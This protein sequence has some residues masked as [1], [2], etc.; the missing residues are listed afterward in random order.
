MLKPSHGHYYYYY[1]FLKCLAIFS[2]LSMAFLFHP[3]AH[4]GP[5]IQAIRLGY[6]IE[7][8]R[9]VFDL[10][11][12][13]YNQQWVKV[14]NTDQGLIINLQNT[15]LKEKF[16]KH[17]PNHSFIKAIQCFSSQNG[18]SCLIDRKEKALR[19]KYF[20]IPG[21]DQQQARFVVDIFPDSNPINSTKSPENNNLA[22]AA[23]QALSVKPAKAK[24]VVLPSPRPIN[25]NSIIMI[26]PGHGGRDPGAI[27][28]YGSKEKDITL[29]IAKFLQTEL[30]KQ[31][32]K[33]LL[34]RQK[35]RFIPLA[36]RVNRARKEEAMLF[37][38]LHA[39]AFHSEN[40][41]GSSVYVLSEKGA[42][43][44]SAQW[45]A[46]KENRSDLIGGLNL[47]QKNKAV[48]K[49]LL[50][51]SQTATKNKSLGLGNSLLSELKNCTYLHNPKVEKAGFAVLK[52]PDIPSVL[53]ETG[54]LSHPK[55]ELK[56]K[57]QLYQKTLAKYLSLGIIKY[58][59]AQKN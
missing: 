1:H 45:L 24:A 35:D 5:E 38:S 22:K 40:I 47:K 14:Q 2:V 7:K 57:T 39:D 36:E 34:T 11:S 51:M 9:V 13:N 33:A 4:A 43:S 8:L 25:K 27:G 23:K 18:T 52:A 26:D 37:I 6:Y 41:H 56:L 46:E 15:P 10:N 29:S 32:Y 55:S 17:L 44:T 48:A 53:V 59:D 3:M 54:F 31:G 21:T 12:Q 19:A 28:K 49:V 42:S 16:Y 30:Q 50:D 20:L 58:L